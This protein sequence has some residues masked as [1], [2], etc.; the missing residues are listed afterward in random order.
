[1]GPDAAAFAL[2]ERLVIRSKWERRPEGEAF[3]YRS[4]NPLASKAAPPDAE[5]LDVLVYDPPVS[6]AA[7]VA[8]SLF[9]GSDV[10][11]IRDVA[12][13]T[14]TARLEGHSGWISSVH[15]LDDAILTTSYDRTVR[16]WDPARKWQDVLPDAD[17]GS[18]AAGEHARFYRPP[19]SAIAIEGDTAF[20]ATDAGA[21]EEWDPSTAAQTRTSTFGAPIRALAVN[22]RWLAVSAFELAKWA[23]FVARPRTD[24]APTPGA[25][26]SRGDGFSVTGE[27][28]YD[29]DERGVTKAS[30]CGDCCAVVVHRY[31]AAEPFTGNEIYVLDLSRRDAVW[32]GGHSV[33]T[34]HLSERFLA[35]GTFDGHVDVWRRDPYEPIARLSEHAGAITD[36]AVDDTRLLSCSADRTLRIW[37]L[38]TLRVIRTL[39][40]P[41]AVA[42]L[43]VR[44]ELLVTVSTDRT[45]RVFAWRRGLELARFTDDA[46]L[47]ACAIG[48]DGRTL[49]AGGMSGHLQILRATAAADAGP[50]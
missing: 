16:I 3:F 49:L 27:G 42:S 35:S 15:V 45:L 40:H 20:V 36:L 39:S 32:R 2:G 37:D 24:V 46:P 10:V 1:V 29:F 41:E 43:M 11:D 26:G 9:L 13:G 31:Y 8:D 38:A 21:V 30:L 18:P 50:P 34:V 28:E 6:A 17:R 22:D 7:R 48:E 33:V 4:D 44:G 47:A 19:I 12:S 5:P 23:S 14:W 25:A